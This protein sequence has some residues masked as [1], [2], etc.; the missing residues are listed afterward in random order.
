MGPDGIEKELDDSVVADYDGVV[1]KDWIQTNQ[2]VPTN[3]GRAK[4]QHMLWLQMFKLALGECHLEPAV[5][6][7]NLHV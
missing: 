5:Q 2:V 7:C 1:A 6:K 4:D 3:G